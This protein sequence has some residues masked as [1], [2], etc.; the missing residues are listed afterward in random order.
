MPVSWDPLVVSLPDI[1]RFIANQGAT[2]LP[3]MR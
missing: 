3:L 2:G 1:M